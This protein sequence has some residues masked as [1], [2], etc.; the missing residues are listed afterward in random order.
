LCFFFILA[1][2]PTTEITDD[3][4]KRSSTSKD[5]CNVPFRHIDVHTFFTDRNEVVERAINDCVEHLI[6]E[7][8]DELVGSWLLTEYALI[9]CVL[10]YFVQFYTCCKIL[11]ISRIS[12]WDTEK[13]RLVLLST[14]D[15]YSVKY[16]F[17]S[18][19]ILD[20]NRVSISLLDTVVTGELI[21]PSSSLAP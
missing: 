13:E 11:F 8:N 3:T 20:F 19:K 4:P 15:L 21:Y 17:I 18:L 7:N 6:K 1:V 2:R 16:D 10:C 5:V 14:K 9:V 12:L